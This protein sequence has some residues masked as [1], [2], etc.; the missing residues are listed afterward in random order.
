MNLRS[1]E[2]K[3]ERNVQVNAVTYVCINHYD[4]AKEAAMPQWGGTTT[5]YEAYNFGNT[6]T[7]TFPVFTAKHTL[8]I[9]DSDDDDDKAKGVASPSPPPAKKTKYDGKGKGVASP[10]P[11]P[12]GGKHTRFPDSDDDE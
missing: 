8:F 9:D 1:F 6:P 12:G 7:T 4:P 10:S 2:L 3:I 11:T 5:K